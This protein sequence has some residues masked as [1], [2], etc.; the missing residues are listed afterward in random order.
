MRGEQPDAEPTVYVSYSWSESNTELLVQLE[1]VFTQHGCQLVY[2]KRKMHTGDWISMFMREIGQSRH[3][4]VLLDRK[5]LHSWH[6]MNELQY[7]HDIS[8]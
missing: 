3:V 6:S 5:Y 4:L 8:L 1:A 7:L 2:E